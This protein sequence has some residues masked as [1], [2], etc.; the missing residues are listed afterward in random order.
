MPTKQLDFVPD[1]EVIRYR[2]ENG[3]G[4]VNVRPCGPVRVTLEYDGLEEADAN[5][6]DAHYASAKG[7]TNTFDYFDRRAGVTHPGCRYEDYQIV[8]HEKYWIRARRVVIV[9]E[10]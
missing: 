6:L 10:A 3:G 1:F 7:K 2:F 9:R 4:A 8:T 5:L